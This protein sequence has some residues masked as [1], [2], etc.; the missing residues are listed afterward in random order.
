VRARSSRAHLGTGPL[1]TARG[2]N[3]SPRPDSRRW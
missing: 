3:G 1:P 2:L